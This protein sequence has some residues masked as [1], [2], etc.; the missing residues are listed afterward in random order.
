MK[1][2]IIISVFRWV[3]RYNLDETRMELT[4]KMGCFK[5]NFSTPPLMILVLKVM[6]PAYDKC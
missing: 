5:A 1:A 2:K 6:M 3:T 4:R